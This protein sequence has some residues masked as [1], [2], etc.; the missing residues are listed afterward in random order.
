MRFAGNNG[1]VIRLEKYST[2]YCWNCI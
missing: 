1:E 2:W